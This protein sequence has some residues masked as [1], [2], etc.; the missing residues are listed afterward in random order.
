MKKIIIGLLALGSISAFADESYCQCK[1][2]RV[3]T[4]SGDGGSTANVHLELMDSPS[5]LRI[6]TLGSYIGVSQNWNSQRASNR[7]QKQCEEAM[8]DHNACR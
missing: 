8:Q 1:L 3:A 5:G 2:I 7:A 4:H 6:S